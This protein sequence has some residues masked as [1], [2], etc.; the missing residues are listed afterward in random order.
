MRSESS[1]G[2]RTRVRVAEN[3]YK[4]RREDG[5]W[6][7]EATFRDSDGRQRTK[8]LQASTERAAIRETRGLLA[9]RDGGERVVAHAQ[10][11]ESF[12]QQDYFP[13]LDGLVSSGLRAERG[14]DLYRERWRLH[15]SPHLGHR[16]IG[17]VEA[18]HISEVITAMRRKG[19]AEST[20]ASALVVL[21]AIY[22][23]AVGRGL[24]PR[25]PL[26]RLDPAELPR[27]RARGRGR[28]LDEQEL[29]ALVRHA[30]PMYKP[31][32]TALA[33][34]GLRLSEAVGL[35]WSDIDFVG[36]EFK[37]SGQ[38]SMSRKGK[39]AI[40]IPPKTHAGV[41]VVPM[42]PA[43]EEA[44]IALLADEQSAGRGRD[45]D[46]VFVG[47]RG[48]PLHQR[49]VA[50]R[51]VEAAA[52][53]AGLG[54]VTPQDLRCSFCSLSGRRGVD[55][56]EAAQMTGHSL[57]VWMTSYARSFGKPQ[58]DEARERLLAFGLGKVERVQREHGTTDLEADLRV[59]ADIPLTSGDADR[60][61]G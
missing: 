56:I 14:V 20:V 34:S 26:D 41:R 47:R 22:R 54:K 25:S 19:L 4:R 50:V 27:P 11:L 59:S 37:V 35:R 31:V 55:P 48:T 5:T 8:K 13:W 40:V 43:V 17:D 39:P 53:R 60:E 38:L 32:V 23:I 21:R 33:Y 16:K 58:R 28:V 12:V 2:A 7:Y 57:A 44:L 30:D 52:R 42:L 18:H 29:D 61:V 15:I 45:S 24:V 51:G 36:A 9:R 10:N 49:N 1:H 6:V 46:F 3:V